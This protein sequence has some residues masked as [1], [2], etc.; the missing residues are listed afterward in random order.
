[1]RDTDTRIVGGLAVAYTGFAAFAMITP[2]TLAQQWLAAG[3][4]ATSKGIDGRA[5]RIRDAFW[6]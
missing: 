5:G 3:A 6:R 1:V 4:T 2:P